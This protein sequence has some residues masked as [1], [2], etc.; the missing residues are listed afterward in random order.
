VADEYLSRLLDDDDPDVASAALRSAGQLERHKFYPRMI[1]ALGQASTRRAAVEALWRQGD[2]VIPLLSHHLLDPAAESQVRLSIPNILSRMHH[3][4]AVDVLLES[5]L[6]PETGQLLD[7]R[8]LKALWRLHQAAPDLEVNADMV[9]ASANRESAAAES[10]EQAITAF[11]DLDSTNRGVALLQRAIRE[12]WSDRQ[13]GV[14]RCLGL[15][16]DQEGV[17]RCYRALV[18]R[19]DSGRANALEWLEQTLGHARFEAFRPVL[20]RGPT[21]PQIAEGT[22]GGTFL[23]LWSDNDKAL[24]HIALWTAAKLNV[25]WFADRVAELERTEAGAHYH[26]VIGM[27]RSEYAT[28]LLVPLDDTLVDT[29]TPRTFVDPLEKIFLLQNVDV[30]RDAGSAMFMLLATITE[31]VE[32]EP[33]TVLMT[34]GE[35]PEALYVVVEGSV[36]LE[37]KSGQ[38]IEAGAGRP[39]GTWALID[40]APSLVTAK[41]NEPTRLIRVTRAE[42]HDLL[43]DYPE[44]AT[45][46]LQGLARKVRALVE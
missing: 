24:A 31:E 20:S 34:G 39:F 1:S 17:L 28:S 3:Q 35:P 7:F 40:R 41:V 16:Y 4:A 27:T 8:S 44:L 33:G 11:R 37:A 6:A 30:L 45:E 26:G 2:R 15:L 21:P 36:A 14:F 32:A 23:K 43:A 22:L 12:A 18:A 38:V 19:S 5:F 42:F 10:Y 9:L 13:E 25:P 46:L 29:P